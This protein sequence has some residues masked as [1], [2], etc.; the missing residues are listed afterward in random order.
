MEVAVLVS[1]AGELGLTFI[2]AEEGK[3]ELRAAQ[4]WEA[5]TGAAWAGA[6]SGE[7]AVSRRRRGGERRGGQD[8]GFCFG[9]KETEVELGELVLGE[10]RSDQGTARG[11][12]GGGAGVRRGRR[13]GAGEL[14][15]G[16]EVRGIFVN[17][18]SFRG[19]TVRQGFL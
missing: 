14:E 18:Q 1:R 10:V 15:V 5:P 12:P 19:S 13:Q 7:T 6:G 11:R 8:F 9:I 16:D 17:R 4:Q 3:V 2:G